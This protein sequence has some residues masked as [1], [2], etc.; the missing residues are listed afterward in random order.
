MAQSERRREALQ[1]SEEARPKVG[2]MIHVS[3][4]SEYECRAAVIT[5]H[6]ANDR[7]GLFVTV[8]HPRIPPYP[9]VIVSGFDWHRVE[10]CTNG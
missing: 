8:F 5:D 1:A 10:D 9:A 7:G 2:T 6:E 4:S 3:Y